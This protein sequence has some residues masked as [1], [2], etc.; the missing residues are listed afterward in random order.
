MAVV[1]AIVVTVAMVVAVFVAK[2]MIMAMTGDVVMGLFMMVVIRIETYP[3]LST[4]TF[5]V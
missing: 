5:L 3:P 2:A 4:T 1:V